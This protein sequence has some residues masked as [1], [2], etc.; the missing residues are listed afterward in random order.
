M[1]NEISSSTF[2]QLF[3]YWFVL[4]QTNLKISK[5]STTKWFSILRDLYMQSWRKYHNLNHI[6]HLLNL[7]DKYHSSFDTSSITNIQL[8]IWFHDVIYVPSRSDNEDVY[9]LIILEKY[10]II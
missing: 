2:E 5:E 4:C 9:N 6:C 10:T 8:T 3:K 7:F 1:L